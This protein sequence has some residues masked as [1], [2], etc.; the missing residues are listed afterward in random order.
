MSVWPTLMAVI[1]SVPTLPAPSPVLV[2]VGI[3]SPAMAALAM[4]RITYTI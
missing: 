3:L 1:S 4:V 2:A